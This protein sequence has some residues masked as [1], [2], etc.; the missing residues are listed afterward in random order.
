[1][2]NIVIVG[3]GSAGWLSALYFNTVRKDYEITVIE[4]SKI[5]ILGAGEGT[6]PNFSKFL[7]LV[8]IDEKDF[9]E[10]TKSSK[11]VSVNFNNWRGDGTS[12][13]NPFFGIVMDKPYGWHFDARLLAEYFKS[14]SL[15]R[16]V[17]L[18]D[19]IVSEFLYEGEDIQTIV[20][21]EGLKLKSDVVIDCTGFK[22]LII[23]NQYKSEWV[24]YEKY[25]KTNSALIFFQK[26]NKKITID[27]PTRTTCTAMKYGWL[28]EIPIQHRIGTGYIYDS[29][30]INE[31][32]AKSEIVEYM[33]YTPEFVNSFKFNPGCFRETWKGN[34]V[35]IGL[36]S[37]FLEPLEATSIMTS[38]MQLERFN[39]TNFDKTKREFYNDLV[40]NIN[41]QNMIFV[42]YH[43][44]CD[45][46]DS[47]FWIDNSNGP[48]PEKLLKIL[49]ENYDVNIDNRNE[50]FSAMEG[51]SET[52]LTFA[53]QHYL[54]INK[55]NR[56]KYKNALI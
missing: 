39:E 22:R 21:K 17:K 26:Q 42:K 40:Y 51:M 44:M 11:K 45:R 56:L 41:E 36:S 30:Y 4:S 49:D 52:A 18:V 13:Q 12:Y 53:V 19:D 6:V 54:L 28:F 34:C 47:Q 55:G 37:G 16:G 7:E 3:G 33:G 32:E 43:Y 29:N 10:K 46:N 31:E 8:K 2:K 38:I 24:S 1:M 20:T 25:L 35:A 5:G 14:I 48:I 50:L 9:F 23:G 15:Q 27:T